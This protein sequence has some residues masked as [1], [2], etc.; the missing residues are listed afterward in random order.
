MRSLYINSIFLYCIVSRVII[1]RARRLH[2][3]LH[4]R[5]GFGSPSG[6][7]SSRFWQPPHHH[8]GQARHV[9][10]EPDASCIPHCVP[11]QWIAFSLGTITISY[12]EFGKSAPARNLHMVPCNP[13]YLRIDLQNHQDKCGPFACPVSSSVRRDDSDPMS[14]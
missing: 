1:K 9:T 7:T 8:L 4:S 6:V 2:Y 5:Q 10:G 3:V 14:L 11:Q 12:T 13:I